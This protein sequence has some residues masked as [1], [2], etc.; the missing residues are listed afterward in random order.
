M[1]YMLAVKGYSKTT[2][3][4]LLY[5]EPSWW[6]Q[7]EIK[8]DPRLK[9]VVEDGILDYEAKLS[10]DEMRE[11]HEYFKPSATT[12]FYATENWQKS[13]QPKLTAL[14]SALTE[15]ADEFSHFIVGLY[16]WSS[17]L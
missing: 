7:V 6:R 13:I 5:I 16:D 11:M 2:G 9:E 14:D 15:R 8:Q 4:R 12:G 17:G 3:E 1:A 10:V